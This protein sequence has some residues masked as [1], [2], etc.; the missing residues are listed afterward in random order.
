MQQVSRR[1]RVAQT[2]LGARGKDWAETYGEGE[3]TIANWKAGDNYPN[4]WFLT[5]LCEDTGLTMDFFYRGSLAGVAERLVKPLRQAAATV[6]GAFPSLGEP[7][8]NT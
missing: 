3:S 1:L 5:R 2:A 8:S 4:P 6:P 7:P